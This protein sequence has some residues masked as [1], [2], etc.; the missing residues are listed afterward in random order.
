MYV[1][2]VKMAFL[3]MGH[4]WYHRKQLDEAWQQSMA[5][6]PRPPEPTLVTAPPGFSR[7]SCFYPR[8]LGLGTSNMLRRHRATGVFLQRVAKKSHG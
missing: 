6:A 2:S 8:K 4:N 5:E 7:K 3:G 1:S